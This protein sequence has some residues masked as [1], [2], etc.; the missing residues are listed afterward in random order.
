MI[1]VTKRNG[2]K[3]TVD[4]EKIHQILFFAC[5]NITGVS[6]SEIEMRSQI[7]FYDGIS[8][9][10]IH[11]ILIKAC[12]ELI[13]TESPNYQYVAGRL[14]NYGLRK[15]VYGDYNPID[16]LS[17]IQKCV[18]LNVYDDEILSKY[19]QDE[20]NELGKYIKHQRDDKYTYTAME[21]WRGKYLIQNRATKQYYETPQMANMMIAATLFINYTT[22]RMKY[23]KDMY[24]ALSNFDISL[25]TPLMGG[26]RSSTRQF[27]SCVVTNIGDDLDSIGA[28]TQAIIR[29]ISRRAGL[30]VNMGRIRAVNSPIRNGEAVHTGLLPFIKLIQSAVKSCSQ[31]GL[32]GGAATLFFPFWHYEFEDLIVLKNNKGV[33]DARARKVDYCFQFNGYLYQRLLKNEN[34]SFFSPHDVPGLYNAFCADQ[35]EFIRLYEKYEATPSIRRRTLSAREAFSMFATERYETGRIYL[36]NIDHSN[37]HS[38][39]DESVAPIEQSNLCLSGDTT[40]QVSYKKITGDKALYVTQYMKMKRLNELFHDEN[41]SEFEV[42]SYDLNTRE[43]VF[44]PIYN[45]A[46]MNESA[47][48]LELKTQRGEKLICT[49]T[50]K[51]YIVGKGYIEAKDI[52]IGEQLLYTP[53]NNNIV[54]D[55]EVCKKSQMSIRTTRED[56]HTSNNKNAVID[57]IVDVQSIETEIPVYDITV[58]GTHC[59]F[60]NNVLVHNCMEIDLPSKPFTDVNADDGMISLCTLAAI[61]WGNFN[62]P[63]DMQKACE[64]AVRALDAVLDYQEYP[65]GHAERATKLYR[66]LGVGIINF[67]YFLAKRGLKYDDES[68]STVHEWTEAWSY[69]LLRASADL[70]KEQGRCEGF[71]DL[72]YA[73]GILPIDTYKSAID[74]FVPNVLNMPWDELRADILE[75]GIRNATVMALMPSETSSQISNSTNGIEPIRSLVT[76]KVSKDGVL[77]QVVPEITKLKN[78]Y[79][80]LWD[81][82]TPE[83]YLKVCGVIQKFVD[84]GISANTSYNPQLYPD[85]KIPMVQ[86]LKDIMFAYKVGLKSLYYNNTMDNAKEVDVEKMIAENTAPETTEKV[87]PVLKFLKKETTPEPTVSSAPRKSEYD[88]TARDDDND[89]KD[90]CSI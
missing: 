80:L 22:D 70:A 84:Q 81:Q 51:I 10:E 85:A 69:Y 3:E 56:D 37:T 54:I 14:I 24:D 21:Q 67:A 46:L 61:N 6:V 20:L 49:P 4:Y 17:H 86:L 68:L 27:S 78:K 15:E 47:K 42:E 48:V 23:V 33:D 44:K 32:R 36:Q 73:K 18:K 38:P 62:K 83:G 2:K 52:S 76:K 60:A 16:F 25:P 45:S 77:A 41:C 34:I 74:E 9:K 65:I 66:P 5:E 63:E 40:V 59:F 79:D 58:S 57:S 35:A 1:K 90:G 12:A 89:C 39:F 13:S 19:T 31:G 50:H 72:K 82:K 8:T 43:I 64:L 29:Y 53:V 11:S 7:Q 28:G 87:N 88:F 26:L 71:N 55:G 30:G 75:N